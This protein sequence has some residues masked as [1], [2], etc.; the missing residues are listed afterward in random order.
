VGISTMTLPT[1]K[2]PLFPFGFGLSYSSFNISSILIEGNIGGADEF[3]TVS[4]SVE[5]T[6][7]KDGKKIVQFYVQAPADGAVTRAVKELKAFQKPLVKAQSSQTVSVK[8]DKYAVSF[9]D[10]KSDCWRAPVGT[11]Q[12]P[13]GFS[14]A[15]IVGSANIG[16]SEGFT[17]KGL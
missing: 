7:K 10:V 1:A 17:W 4:C 12:L 9:Y 8:M 15:E 5:N 16:V 14:A 6:G 13:V 11:Y 2:V 3:V